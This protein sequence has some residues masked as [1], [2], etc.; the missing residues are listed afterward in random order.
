MTEDEYRLVNEVAFAMNIFK[1]ASEN[2][3]RLRAMFDDTRVD[4]YDASSGLAHARE[5]LKTALDSYIDYRIASKKS[6]GI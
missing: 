4:S 2:K 5:R 6:D 3:F 1:R